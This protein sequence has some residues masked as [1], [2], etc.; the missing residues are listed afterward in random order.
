MKTQLHV[1]YG[2]AVDAVERRERLKEVANKLSQSMGDTARDR[3]AQRK[4]P[5]DYYLTD[6]RQFRQ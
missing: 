4:E 2:E 6:T 3:Y 1:L 5:L